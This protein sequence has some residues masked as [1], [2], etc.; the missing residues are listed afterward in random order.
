MS[1]GILSK[2]IDDLLNA[3]DEDIQ[4][5]LSQA[6]GG[7]EDL[8]PL[9]LAAQAAHRAIAAIEIDSVVEGESRERAQEALAATQAGR[10]AGVLGRLR[11]LLRGGRK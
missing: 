6:P 3:E 7:R 1:V 9:L 5:Y 10:P 2:Y 4:H 11:G 8:L